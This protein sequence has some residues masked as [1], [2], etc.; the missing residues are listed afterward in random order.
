MK[1]LHES[2]DNYP[3]DGALGK[4]ALGSA[5]ILH[6]WSKQSSAYEHTQ[7]LSE[8]C[9]WLLLWRKPIHCMW[10]KLFQPTDPVHTINFGYDIWSHRISDLDSI[11][12]C[13]KKR[14]MMTIMK[15]F[16]SAIITCVRALLTSTNLFR[17]RLL[18]LSKLPLLSS[19]HCGVQMHVAQSVS[20]D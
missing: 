8:H 3:L 2:F 4:Y 9:C 7:V 17:L 11:I 6:N 18:S 14:K 1:L 13:D 15:I 19:N 10:F 5:F 12:Q 16:R 20:V